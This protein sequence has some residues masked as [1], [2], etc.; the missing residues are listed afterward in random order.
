MV[1]YFEPK[2]KKKGKLTA[3][4]GQLTFRGKKQLSYSQDALQI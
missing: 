3:K 1:K 4:T 2:V